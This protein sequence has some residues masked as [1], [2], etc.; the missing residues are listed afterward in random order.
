M[1]ALN[2]FIVHIPKKYNDQW[3][4]ESGMKWYLSEFHNKRELANVEV[5]VVATPLKLKTCI[6]K[7]DTLLIDIISIL[8]SQQYKFGNTGNHLSVDRKKGIY[9]VPK[10]LVLLYKKKNSSQWNCFQDKVV[11][12]EIVE[13]VKQ[14]GIIISDVR[15]KKKSQN[16]GIVRVLNNELKEQGVNVGDKVMFDSRTNIDFYLEGKK[17]MWT[18]TR[19]ILAYLV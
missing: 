10:D 17:H 15:Q 5:E 4:S 2:D 11:L 14:S 6:A 18:K 7:G 13:E 16:T 12:E 1:Q 19:H 8:D 3:I 9:R